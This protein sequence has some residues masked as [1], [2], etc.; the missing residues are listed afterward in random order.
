MRHLIAT[1]RRPIIRRT[2]AVAAVALGVLGGDVG[3][4]SATATS[5]VNFGSV[6]LGVTVSAKY[7]FQIDSGDVS[8]GEDDFGGD[9]LGV[10]AEPA[11]N[12]QTLFSNVC[13]ATVTFTPSA[14]GPYAEGYQE[15][16]CPNAGGSCPAADDVSLIGQGIVVTGDTLS[17]T[18]AADVA[19]SSI[20]VASVSPCPAGA[21]SQSANVA[22][23]NS[24]GTTVA[25]L[26]PKLLDAEG[27]W[28]GVLT[29]PSSLSN[30]S[31]FIHAQCLT[32]ST[33]NAV[34]GYAPITIV[35][36][37]PV[38]ALPTPTPT[39]SS[40]Q[41]TPVP[42]PLPAAVSPSVSQIQS[43]LDGISHPSGE[44]AV[45]AL[46][47]TDA[48][49]TSFSAPSGGTLSVVWTTRVTIGK[50]KHKKTKTVT[51]ATG[52]GRTGSATTVS[53]VVRVTAAGKALLKQKPS[54]LP[55][56][57]TERFTPTAGAPSTVTKT[58]RL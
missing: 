6:P 23:D 17:A 12:C 40:S 21:A 35:P 31:Y 26:A 43:S 48:F 55:I 45:A 56:T 53:V 2:L 38:P 7:L 41:T 4:A 57:D 28:A 16:E 50:D 36:V 14:V 18:P 27:N 51:V 42:T 58:F 49:K 32:G 10:F 30:G 39:P 20:N 44:K 52:S 15:L 19:G 1:A 9:D 24:S 46:D 34:Y 29:L 5:N 22:L 13:A 25:T 33:T 47:K 8:A 3:L 11:L 54:G 37:T